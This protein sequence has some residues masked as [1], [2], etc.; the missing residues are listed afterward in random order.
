MVIHPDTQ[1]PKHLSS[2]IV[3]QLLKLAGDPT[4]VLI[5]L[6]FRNTECK[7][8]E[9]VKVSAGQ[10]MCARIMVGSVSERLCAMEKPGLQRGPN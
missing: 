2:K 4:V 1:K 10:G 8:S 7:V 6:V 5:K 3:W 9:V